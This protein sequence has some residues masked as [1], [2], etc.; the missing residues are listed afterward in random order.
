MFILFLLFLEPIVPVSVD[1]NYY[2]FAI[3]VCNRTSVDNALNGQKIVGPGYVVGFLPE[4]FNHGE[5]NDLKFKLDVQTPKM[6]VKL[7]KIAAKNALTSTKPSVSI[8][9]TDV[10]TLIASPYKPLSTFSFLAYI[11]LFD[12]N[13]FTFLNQNFQIQN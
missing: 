6:L 2:G 9:D 10:E 5:A 4:S 7:I 1:V 11:G 8:D 3:C 13:L 12:C